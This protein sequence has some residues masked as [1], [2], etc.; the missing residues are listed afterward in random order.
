LHCKRPAFKRVV[1]FLPKLLQMSFI[2]IEIKAK[3][4]KADTIRAYLLA[5][6]AVFKGTDTQTDTYFNSLKGRLKLRQGNIENNLIYYERNNQAGPKQS[7]FNLVAVAD[8]EGLKEMLTASMGVK[9]TVAKLREIYFI[10]NVKFHL[11]KLE[12]LGS[13][14]EIEAS[15]KYAQCTTAQLNEQCNFYM[16]Q[17]GIESTDLIDISY[18]DML[19]AAVSS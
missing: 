8:A 2:N 14:V 13:F 18:S 15:N 19:L 9:V 7:N 4:S 12:K 10:G 6:G 16:Q 5:H 1:L 11:D 17:F 3:T